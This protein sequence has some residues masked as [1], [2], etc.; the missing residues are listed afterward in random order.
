M[1]YITK[2]AEILIGAV[3]KGTRLNI[4]SRNAEPVMH[5]L[6]RKLEQSLFKKTP[7]LF[8]HKETLVA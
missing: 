7:F 4:L 5:L 8:G 3:R 2:Y 6:E 1:S